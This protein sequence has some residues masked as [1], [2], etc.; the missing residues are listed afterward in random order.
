MALKFKR[1][2]KCWQDASNHR[3]TDVDFFLEENNWDDYGYIT[4]YHLHVSA[5]LTGGSPIYLGALRIMK[6]GQSKAD[7]Y[8]LDKLFKD[9]VFSCLPEG[10]IS[11]SMDIDLYMGLNRWLT[12][13]EDRQEFIKALHL[14]LGEDSEFFDKDLYDNECFKDSLL[15]D[16]NDL[17][18]FALK[19]GKTLLTG[20]EC[21]YDLRR[22]KISVQYSHVA[23]E[24]DLNFSCV[25]EDNVNIP[26]GIMVFIGKNGSGKS[27]AIYKL[28]KL[29]YTDPT[30]RFRMK[31]K[32]GTLKP[33][34]V[35][36]SK[37]FLISYSPFDNFV[38]P[39]SYDKDYIKLL[40][41]GEDVT[42]RFVF[43]GIRNLEEEQDDIVI[44]A[45]TDE[46]QLEML[47]EDRRSRTSLKDI[48]VLADEFVSALYP[49][50]DNRLDD[51]VMT[52][53]SFMESCSKKQPSLY[54]DIKEITSE[55][56]EERLK[57]IFLSLSTGHKFF[58]HTYVRL[59]A[60]IDDNSLLLFDEP[61]NHLH[62]PLL[63]FLISSVRKLLN[64]Y[65]SVMFVATHSPVI[66]QETFADNV[67]VVRKFEGVST[68]S[69]PGIE[70]YGANIAAITSEVFDL[71]TG[72]TEYHDAIKFLYKKWAMGMKENV[73]IM[74]TEFEKK[75]GHALTDQVETYLIN[76]YA[77]D[78]DVED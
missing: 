35:G 76:L 73:E 39:T 7:Y 60:Y 59:V 46:A 5:K 28:A 25:E 50:L 51:R 53:Y 37:M 45:D 24:V 74:L 19:K 23:N 13:V 56:S 65:K 70:T 22:E 26:N 21:Y 34:N 6:K 4:M 78:N 48:S 12:N 38:L 47:L 77:R 66:L 40:K 75:L 18:N 1:I 8:L 10:F 32:V 54:D 52:W 9:R 64:K 72:I 55:I 61:E 17:D 29:M 44:N 58:L 20:A 3:E 71:T 42:S 41:K 67:F 33:N 15:R 30:Q 27:T 57:E 16:T 68:I 43:C 69:H 11:L 2:D 31:A 63:S 49:L 62:P 14:I 36:V